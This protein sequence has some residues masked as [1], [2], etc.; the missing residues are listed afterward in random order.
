MAAH[1]IGYDLNRP[2]H[3]YPKLIEGIKELGS[4][5]HCLDSTWIVKSPLSCAQIKE[6]LKQFVDADDEL[7]VV[8]LTGEGAWSFEQQCSDWLAKNL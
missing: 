6:T 7:L 3:S 8:K 2:E 5:W 4:W 1:L